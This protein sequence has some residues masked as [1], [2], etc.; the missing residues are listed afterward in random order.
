MLSESQYGD[1]KSSLPGI[2][3][4]LPGVIFLDYVMERSGHREALISEN[5]L[6]VGLIVEFFLTR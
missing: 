5:E 6:P 3:K 2:D 4:V 1:L